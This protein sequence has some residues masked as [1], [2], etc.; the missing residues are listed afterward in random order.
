M[1]I[2]EILYY[3]DQVCSSDC[4][5]SLATFSKDML[6]SGFLF[7][8]FAKYPLNDGPWCKLWIGH[9]L[10]P[11]TPAAYGVPSIAPDKKDTPRDLVLR[12]VVSQY[13]AR[14]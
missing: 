1:K 2:R 11:Q 9:D 4:V 12:G 10:R 8:A 6:A 3:E 7:F 14:T 5:G 13:Q